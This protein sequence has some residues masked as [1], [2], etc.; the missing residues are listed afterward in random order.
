MPDTRLAEHYRKLAREEQQKARQ[1]RL[2]YFAA[3]HALRAAQ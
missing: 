1:S 2:E 3:Q